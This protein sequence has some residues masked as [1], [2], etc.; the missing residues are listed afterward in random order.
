MYRS[1]PSANESISNDAWFADD[2]VLLALSQAVCNLLNARLL[3]LMSIL[4]FLLNSSVKYC[5]NRLSI[6]S[7]PKK[8]LYR[9]F[10]IKRIVESYILDLSFQKM[11]NAEIYVKN[12]TVSIKKL[13]LNTTYCFEI[14]VQFSFVPYWNHLCSLL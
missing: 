14:L 3:F 12:Y 2:N 10:E 9:L 7:P 8:S 11:S 6:S 13:F 1:T 4:P 5:T